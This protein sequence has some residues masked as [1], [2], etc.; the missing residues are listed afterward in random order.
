MDTLGQAKWVL[1]E[2][3]LRDLFPRLTDDNFEVTSPKTI[4]YNCIAWAAGAM[5][6]WWQPGVHWPIDSSRYD[7]GIGNLVEAFRSLG[8]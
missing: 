4:K 1:A 8:Y 7:H 6:R 3:N 2:M 5:D